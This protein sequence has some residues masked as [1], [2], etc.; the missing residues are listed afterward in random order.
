M[1]LSHIAKGNSQ[2]NLLLHLAKADALKI[3][4]HGHELRRMTSTEAVLVE[5]MMF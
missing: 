1:L 3:R 2:I 4:H 5:V